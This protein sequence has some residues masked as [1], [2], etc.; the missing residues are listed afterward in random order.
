MIEPSVDSDFERIRDHFPDDAD[1]T[2]QVLKGHLL[3]E[4]QLRE[5]FSL[6]LAFPDALLGERGT[7]FEC[8][9]IICLVQA[10]TP[11]SALE[12]WVWDAAKRLNGVRNAFAHN[13]EPQAIDDKIRSLT[14]FVNRQESVKRVLAKNTVP[15]GM[16]FKAIVLA[17]CGG[18]SSLKELIRAEHGSAA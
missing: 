13:L 12:L 11:H 5:I 17:M 10:I 16:E 1:M 2:L 14:E 3:V 4:E 9:Q 6:L 8:H 15:P 7:K 18:L